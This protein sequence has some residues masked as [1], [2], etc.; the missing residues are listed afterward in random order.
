MTIGIGPSGTFN[1]PG[2]DQWGNFTGSNQ[3]LVNSG[4]Y[5]YDK[6][7]ALVANNSGAWQSAGYA[8]G[9]TAFTNGN[10]RPGGGWGGQTGTWGG[11]APQ[12]GANPLTPGGNGSALLTN[13]QEAFNNGSTGAGGQDPFAAFRT[14]QLD[15]NR[16]FIGGAGISELLNPY[17]QQVRDQTMM[18]TERQRRLAQMTTDDAANRARAFGDDRHGVANALTNDAFARAAA[19][20][21]AGLNAQGFN[22]AAQ[23]AGQNAQNY[24]TGRGQDIG[25][26]IGFM[27]GALQ[28]RQQDIGYGLGQTA[29]QLGAY[30]TAGSLLNQSGLM[31]W[32]SVNQ[33]ANATG[34]LPSNQASTTQDGGS[35][36]NNIIGGLF[37]GLGLLRG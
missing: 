1:R 31:D 37:T 3:D 20:Q 10:Y 4:S 22:T 8:P 19:Q 25:Q 2:Y 24:M 17:M 9:Q 14:E 33:G 29:N 32:L 6:D 12:P 27:G 36:W 28:Q 18:D 15:P 35:N 26:N 23:L 13:G 11:G 16:A 7:G 30:Q 5:Y 21:Y 34:S